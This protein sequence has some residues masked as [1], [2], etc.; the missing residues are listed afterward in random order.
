MRAPVIIAVACAAGGDEKVAQIVAHLVHRRFGVAAFGPGLG[1]ESFIRRADEA[2]YAAKR[3]GK[4][5]VT[6]AEAR[7][8]LPGI[9]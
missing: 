9:R 3:E 1:P 4:N 8:L 7:P 5:R 6:V 2:V